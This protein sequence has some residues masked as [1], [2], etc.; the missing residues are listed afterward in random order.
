MTYVDYE[1]L[2]KRL[3]DEV[4]KLKRDVTGLEQP[5]SSCPFD[6]IVVLSSIYRRLRQP[7]RLP[8]IGSRSVY[9][10]VI[11]AAFREHPLQ[12]ANRSVVV[13]V[14]LDDASKTVLR[15][16][17]G[18]AQYGVMVDGEI[19]QTYTSLKDVTKDWDF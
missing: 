10:T 16:T 17:C 19:V 13:L 2:Y 1:A 12:D 4:I 18:E 14:K 11:G 3:A 7:Q 8:K 6:A 15:I 9:G 5:G